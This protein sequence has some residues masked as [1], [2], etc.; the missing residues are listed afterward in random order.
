[1]K[2]TSLIVE[3]KPG[4]YTSEAYR[5]LRTN[6]QYLSSC[7]GLKI[8]LVTS[9]RQSEGKSTIASNLSITLAQSNKKT[10]LLD[11]DLRKPSLCKMLNLPNDIGLS[12]LLNENIDYHAALNPYMKNLHVITSG[13][14]AANPVEMLSSEKMKSFI[15]TVKSDYDYIVLDSPPALVVTDAR[16]LAS[17]TCGVLLIV[18]KGKTDIDM[19]VKT[20]EL[21]QNVGANIIGVILN[22]TDNKMGKEYSAYSNY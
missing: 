4:S 21:L 11:C 3:K 2:N 18:A 14:S 8:I 22:K 1:M 5:M 13:D 20:K 17:L 10:L 16:V 12:N 7:S 15:E 9:A 19:V 6:I